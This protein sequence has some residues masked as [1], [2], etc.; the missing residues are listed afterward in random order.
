MGKDSPATGNLPSAAPSIAQL[1]G[2]LHFLMV[3]SFGSSGYSGG[4]GSKHDPRH[5]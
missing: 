2:S 4:G 1:F 5:L 3:T